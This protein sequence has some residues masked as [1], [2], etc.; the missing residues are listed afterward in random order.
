MAVGLLLAASA[1]TAGETEKST[2]REVQ[3]D[4]SSEMVC[5]REKV[6]GSNIKK[7]VCR[8]RAQEEEMRRASQDTVSEFGRAATRSEG[9][10]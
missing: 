2:A 8:T 6:V 1:A 3:Q 10:Q 4:R 9:T 5:T 7:R